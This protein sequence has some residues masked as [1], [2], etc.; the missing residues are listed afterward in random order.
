VR[1]IESGQPIRRRRGRDN[2]TFEIIDNL[3]QDAIK[4]LVCGMTSYHPNDVIA[5]YC[6]SCHKFHPIENNEEG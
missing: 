6:G 5:Q 3:K 2:D 1:C 4:C